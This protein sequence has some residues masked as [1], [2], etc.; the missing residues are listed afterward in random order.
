M[1]I[2]EVYTQYMEIKSA[3]ISPLTLKKFKTLK[4]VLLEFQ[5]K[6]GYSRIRFLDWKIKLKGKRIIFQN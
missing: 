4:S 6:N 3:D 2:F 1:D 5:K